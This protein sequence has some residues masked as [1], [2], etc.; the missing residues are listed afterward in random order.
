MQSAA[1]RLDAAAPQELCNAVNTRQHLV[2]TRED[3]CGR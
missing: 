1:E 3:N 2:N